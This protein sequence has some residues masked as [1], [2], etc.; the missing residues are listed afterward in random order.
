MQRSSDGHAQNVSFSHSLFFSASA[1]AGHH[2]IATT[3]L[4]AADKIPPTLDAE[5]QQLRGGGNA[6]TDSE[7]YP[8]D[9]SSLR[10]SMP[11]DEEIASLSSQQ[12]LDDIAIAVVRFKANTNLL[13]IRDERVPTVEEVEQAL[14]RGEPLLVNHPV[15]WDAN[16]FQHNNH[17]PIMSSPTK[18]ED[19]FRHVELA[20]D[21]DSGRE[22]PTPS[23][24]N[25]EDSTTRRYESMLR[26]QNHG[27]EDSRASLESDVSS[28]EAW[29]LVQ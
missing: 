18:N 14:A 10:S 20:T 25:L 12:I 11:S 8:L 6:V 22:A 5:Q 24:A 26:M 28:K 27:W 1:I 9:V 29:T 23:E 7:G 3:K 15:K 4:L 2:G 13:H 19:R 21:A 17:D 16:F